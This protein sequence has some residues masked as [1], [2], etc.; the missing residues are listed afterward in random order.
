[1]EE[2]N[3]KRQLQRAVVVFTLVVCLSAIAGGLGSA[4]FS[5]YF[6]EVYHVDSAQRGFLEIP[7]ESPGVLCALIISALAGFSDIGIAA[8]SQVLVMVGL[9]VMG[10]FSPSYGMMMIFLFIQSLGMHLFMPLNDAISMDLAREGEVGKTLGNFK[11]KANMCTMVTAFV[12]FA[13][14]RWG[15]FSFEDKILKPFVIAAILSLIAAGL[16]VYM[17]KIMPR[18]QIQAKTK[19]KFAM[20][21]K[22]MP[23]YLT[24]VAYGCQKRIKLVFGPW[25]IIELMGKGADTVALLGIVTS[26]IGAFFSKYLGKM[27]DEKGLKYTMIFEGGYLLVVIAALGAAAGALERGGLGS[28]GIWV[29]LAYCLYIL[30]FLLEQFNM[31]HAFM[32]RKL[33]IDPSEV[34]ASLSVG[35]SLDHILAITVSAVLGVIWEKFGAEYVFFLTAATSLMQIGVGLYMGRQLAKQEMQ[36]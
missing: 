31:V 24:L 17:K 11:S 29:F 18:T 16:L 19:S 35:L 32:M 5:N 15:F 27:L 33:A 6:K 12:I 10:A 22:Y 2:N 36:R 30:A 1:M 3:K 9:M 26:F 13:G 4:T 14:Y 21:K 7:R 28:H 34:T 25:I 23:Y 8:V 20:R